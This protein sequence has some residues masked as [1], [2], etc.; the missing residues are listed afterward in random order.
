MHYPASHSLA[1][2][3]PL[4]VTCRASILSSVAKQLRFKINGKLGS[5][6]KYGMDPQEAA[7]KEFDPKGLLVGQRGWGEE[8]KEA[9]GTLEIAEGS[10][11]KTEV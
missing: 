8:P 11:W 2:P 5:Y 4:L 10:D 7:L 6:T 3:Y 9:W 1:D